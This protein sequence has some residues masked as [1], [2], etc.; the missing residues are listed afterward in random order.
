MC[1]GVPQVGTFKRRD[2]YGAQRPLLLDRAHFELF[3]TASNHKGPCARAARLR[4]ER[5]VVS[6]SLIG[7]SP[8]LGYEDTKHP[9][10]LREETSPNDGTATMRQHTLGS[11]AVEGVDNTTDWQEAPACGGNYVSRCNR[12]LVEFASTDNDSSTQFTNI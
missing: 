8:P 10:R 11:V 7:A 5:R 3:D 1:Q 12:H 4:R 9:A 2:R 6:W